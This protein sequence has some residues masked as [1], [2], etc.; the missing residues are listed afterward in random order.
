MVDCRMAIGEHQ[1][2][3]DAVD[4]VPPPPGGVGSQGALTRTELPAPPS[5]DDLEPLRVGDAPALRRYGVALARGGPVA[6]VMARMVSRAAGRLEGLGEFRRVFLTAADRDVPVVA[7]GVYRHWKDND[8]RVL[9][10][11]RD[12]NNDAHREDVVVYVSLSPPFA[13][14]INVRRLTEFLETVTT[15]DGRAVPR[16]KLRQVQP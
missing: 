7:P 1:P 10:T 3:C 15:S 12:S 5:V 11:A 6:H 8:Y 14:N 9:F 13:G 4:P 16:F 2:G